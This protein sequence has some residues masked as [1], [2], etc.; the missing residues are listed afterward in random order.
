MSIK[1]ISVF[2]GAHLGNNPIYASEAKKVAEVIVEKGMNV[3]FG[4]GDVGL[5]GVVSHTAIDNGGEVLGISLQSLYELE[6]TNPRI[7][8]VV[9]AQT[10]LERK[11]IFM[12]RSDAFIV[13]PG[14][15]GSLDELAE[16]MCS[17]QL[18]IINK[19]IGILNTNGYYDHLLAWMQKAVEEGFV[20]DANFNELIVSDSCEDLIERVASEKRPADD[21]WTNRLGL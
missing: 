2:C 4:G 16:V 6:L 21:D 11:D 14:G 15:V 7:Q 8:E 10:L 20:S 3:V 9:V 17:N 5:M 1:N 19:P 18:G 13:L 12:Q